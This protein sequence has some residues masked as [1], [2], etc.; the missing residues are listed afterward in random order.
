MKNKGIRTKEKKE[1]IIEE[2]GMHYHMGIRYQGL[3]RDGMES[4]EW[5][6]TKDNVLL[7]TC[8]FKNGFMDGDMKLYNEG[9]EIIG[10][11]VYTKGEKVNTLADLVNVKEIERVLEDL[12]KDYHNLWRI[13]DSG[14]GKLYMGEGNLRA[15]IK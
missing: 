7:S 5:K 8:D 12:S 1:H 15:I 10:H 2:I 14:N 13:E 6:M 11:L 3:Y 4:G 9:S